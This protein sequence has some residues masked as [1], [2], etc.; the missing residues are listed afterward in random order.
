MSASDPDSLEETQR[1]AELAPSAWPLLARL[2]ALLAAGAGSRASYRDLLREADEELKSRFLAEEPVEQ[3]VQ[4][5]AA[6]IDLVLRH[7]WEVEL[8][9]EQVRFSLVAVGGYG[10]GE[11]HPCSDIDLLLLVPPASPERSRIERF[12]A[13]LWDMGLEVGHSV[14]TV[15]EC[16][17]QSAAD[18]SV[19]TTLLE[20]RLIAGDAELLAAMRAALSPERV[21]P[22]RE[23]FEAKLREQSARHL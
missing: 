14:R 7:V 18:V 1:G 6:L 13:F 11:L 21:W 8:G 20:A 3:L 22:V 23:F 12:I 16:A 2:P 4:A 15:E 17:E 19:M 10:R 9:D 5:R